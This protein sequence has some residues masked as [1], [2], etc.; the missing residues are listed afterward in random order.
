MENFD[1]KYPYHQGWFVARSLNW[2]YG[3]GI[4]TVKS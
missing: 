2:P 1:G 4:G 3:S